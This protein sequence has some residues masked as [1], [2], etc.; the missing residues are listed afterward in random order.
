[1]SSLPT[2]REYNLLKE[3][4][5]DLIRQNRLLTTKKNQAEKQVAEMTAKAFD[6]LDIYSKMYLEMEDLRKVTFAALANERKK[7]P[8]PS[9]KE[10]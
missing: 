3:E 10:S 6:Y 8:L 5:I 4:N 9:E 2:R 7:R 1:M